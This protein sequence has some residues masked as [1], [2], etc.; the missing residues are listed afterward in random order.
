MPDT[1]EWPKVYCKELFCEWEQEVSAED[2]D[3]TYSDAVQH[4]SLKHPGEDPVKLIALDIKR[5]HTPTGS[6]SSP[7]KGCFLR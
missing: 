2:A 6:H 4:V 3:S 7:H 5:C 1:R